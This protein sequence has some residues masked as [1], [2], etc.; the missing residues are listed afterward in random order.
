VGGGGG[1]THQLEG[2][3][4]TEGGRDRN[5][6]GCCVVS[7]GGGGKKSLTLGEGK[8]RGEKRKRRKRYPFWGGRAPEKEGKGIVHNRRDSGKKKGGLYPLV[9]VRVW[10]IFPKDGL[11]TAKMKGEGERRLIKKVSVD[12]AGMRD[13]PLSSTSGDV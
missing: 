4:S 10:G 8:F 6:G 9:K 2:G 13:S 7:H 5:L 3:K 11:W 1:R 12:P